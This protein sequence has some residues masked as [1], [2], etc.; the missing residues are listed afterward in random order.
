MMNGIIIQLTLVALG[1]G[2]MIGVV[3]GS[4]SSQRATIQAMLVQ[5]AKTNDL[6][7]RLYMIYAQ[8]DQAQAQDVTRG[9][10]DHQ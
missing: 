4:A 1:V 5:Q 7:S 8:N 10:A 6:L 3:T 9:A 2:V